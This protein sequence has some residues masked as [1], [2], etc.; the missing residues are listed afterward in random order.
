MENRKEYIDKMAAKL[1]EWDDEILKL[2]DKATDSTDKVKTEIEN[3][4]KDLQT[5]KDAANQKL[6]E[7]QEVGKDTWG[8][9]KAGA[10][11]TF[12]ALGDSVKK[13]RNILK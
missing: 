4:I 12:D 9:V 1:K 5:K 13:V 6:S 2:Q 8:D 10:E 7:L 11:L 3:H